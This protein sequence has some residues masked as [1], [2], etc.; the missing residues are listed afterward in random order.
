[1]KN[2]YISKLRLRIAVGIAFPL[3]AILLLA[4]C[5]YFKRTPPCVFYELTGLYCIGCGSGRALLSLFSGNITAAFRYQPLVIIFLPFVSYY[6]L[7]MYIAFVFGKDI[8]PFPTIKGRTVGMI[9][10][11]VFIAF[12]ILRNIPFYPFTCLAPGGN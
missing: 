4:F 11:V 12:W 5:L 10:L 3:A 8:L 2:T 7:K 6:C 1:M 9:I